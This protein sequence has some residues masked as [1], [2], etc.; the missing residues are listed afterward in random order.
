M[1]RSGKH[2]RDPTLP[3]TV[4]IQ[5]H[6]GNTVRFRGDLVHGIQGYQAMAP[7]NCLAGGAK[8]KCTSKSP[9]A[10]R[11]RVSMVLEQYKLNDAYYDLTNQHQF[12]V[13][14]M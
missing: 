1:Y 11:A 3:Q 4:R 2:K 8:S 6:V 7:E 9:E 5:P 10:K 12:R 13:L 14:D